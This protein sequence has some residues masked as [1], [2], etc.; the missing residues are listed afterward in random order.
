MAHSFYAYGNNGARHSILVS[1]ETTADGATIVVLC[2]DKGARVMRL[3]KGKYQ[4]LSEFLG[5]QLLTT[6]DPNAP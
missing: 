1:A 6:D 5:D 4:M 2:T 3:D